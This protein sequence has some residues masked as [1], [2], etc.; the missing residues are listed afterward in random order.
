MLY[1]TRMWHIVDLGCLCFLP[2]KPC[3]SLK[4]VP[5]NSRYTEQ[6]NNELVISP[7]IEVSDNDQ[8]KDWF[9]LRASIA[10]EPESE[11]RPK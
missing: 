4:S 9:Q 8:I 7:P 11:L 2:S 3:F 6:T 10:V 1:E 5:L